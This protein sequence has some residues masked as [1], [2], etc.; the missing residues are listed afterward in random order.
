LN[1]NNCKMLML[2]PPSMSMCL[3]GIPSM[4]PQM[5]RGF[6]CA[7][8]FF[9]FSNTACSAPN[10]NSAMSFVG[11][12]NSARIVKTVLT[13][14]GTGSSPCWSFSLPRLLLPKS[15]LW[16]P[17]SG[18]QFP[19]SGL[20]LPDSGIPSPNPG[21]SSPMVRVTLLASLSHP[22]IYPGSLGCPK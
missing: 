2:A 13:S 1:S 15:G 8:R 5:K 14:I 21:L 12:Q 9:S 19:H 11:A 7:P 16:L 6:M 10:A 20:H 4:R 18:W 3:I 17:N 22:S